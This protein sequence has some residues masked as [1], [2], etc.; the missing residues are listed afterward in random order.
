MTPRGPGVVFLMGPTTSGKTAAACLLAD[1][2]EA[3]IISVDSAMVY[4]GL[5]IGTAKPSPAVLGRYPHRLVDVCDPADT[6]SAARFRTDALA[7]IDSARTRGRVPLLVGGTGLYFRVLEAGIATLPDADAG[8]RARLDADLGRL[9]V[10]AL[11]ARLA[12]VDPDSAARIHPRDPQRVLRALE[13]YMAGGRAMSALLRDHAAS[14]LPGPVLRFV[15]A[16]TDRGWLHE[17]IARRFQA[18]LQAGF[19]NEVAALRQRQDLDLKLASLR[20]VGYRAVWRYLDGEY[21]FADMRERAV[22][23]T[24]QLAKRQFTWFRGVDGATWLDAQ[25]ARAAEKIA[26]AVTRQIGIE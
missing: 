9:G 25:D 3:D 15:L 10:E 11:H 12:G 1:R 8:I 17:R 4:R 14:P 6:Y 23:A 24:R 13:V 21:D 7:A 18:M 22:A 16:P 19:V 20:A 5:D 26:V 2:L